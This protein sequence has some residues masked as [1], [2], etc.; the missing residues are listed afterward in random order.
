MRPGA[1]QWQA[2][3]L[4]FHLR[5]VCNLGA[6]CVL[7]EHRFRGIRLLRALLA[8][9][10]YVFTDLSPSGNVIALNTRLGFSTLDTATAVI[11]NLPLPSRGVEV[12][13]RPARIRAVLN[14]VDL[15]TYLDH[16]DD[17]AARHLV[18]RQGGVSCYVMFRKDR[19]KDLPI[20][21]SLLHVSDPALLRESFSALR[22][23]L[24]VRHGLPV[25]LAE[26]RLIGAPPRMSRVLAS[27]RTKMY[28][29]DVAPDH[30]D[31]LYSELTRVAW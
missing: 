1:W 17:P 20:F 14:G 2:Q 19:R 25:T 9:P 28:R 21:A 27:H 15:H 7:E 16:A 4:G 8:Q 18:L 23:H 5:R 29:G 12:V 10:G 26:I 22:R 24:L 30:I 13:S 31:S 6:W 3:P 11:A